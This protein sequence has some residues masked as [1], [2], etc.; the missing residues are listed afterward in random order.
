ME[1][2]NKFR[3]WLLGSPLMVALLFAPFFRPAGLLAFDHIFIDISM[4]W[5]GVSMLC[6]AACFL[7]R[8]R[9]SALTILLAAYQVLQV[10]MTVVRG[11]SGSLSD[12]LTTTASIGAVCALVDLGVYTDIKALIRGIFYC[13]GLFILINLATV[14]IFPGGMVFDPPRIDSYFMG[15]DNGHP[16]FIIPLMAVASL[17]GW[18]RRWRWY[19]LLALMAV[20]GAAVYLT[21]SAAGVVSVSLFLALFALDLLEENEPLGKYRGKVCNICVYYCAIAAVFLLLVILKAPARFSFLIEQVLHKNVTL[22]GRTEL[23]AN[24]MSYVASH[25]FFGNGVY[26]WKDMEQLVGQINC[27]NVYLQCLFDTGL[28]GF[29]LYMAALGLLVK[30]LMRTRKTFGGCALA[31]AVFAA[32]MDLQAESMV[33]DLPYYT[34]FMLSYYAEKVVPAMGPAPEE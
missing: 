6:I 16:F 8:P 33:Y 19:T 24:V 20:F 5:K 11:S 25:P 30:P 28:V 7:T 9:L 27:H 21:W 22:S 14:L 17:Y 13:L 23:W 31:A 32:L 12:W 3:V 26:E 15:R 10:V 4:V 1:R 18:S 2:L 29:A 34:L